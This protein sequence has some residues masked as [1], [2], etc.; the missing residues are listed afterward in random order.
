[1]NGINMA[2]GICDL[3]VPDSVI[4]GAKQAMDQGYNI[5]MPCEGFPDLR[6]AVANR[7]NTQYG[8]AVDPESQVFIS[9]GATGAFYSVCMAM[10]NPGD[11]V[12]LFEPYYGYHTATLKAMDLTPVYTRMSPPDWAIDWDHL[13]S[14]ITLRT[15]AM[16]VNTPG[17]P[18]GKVFTPNRTGAVGR[19]G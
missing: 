4:N 12:I 13:A 8:M 1:M 19:P 14:L 9:A 10:F 7:M 17:N 3:D 11:E 15:R 6:K 2:Q 18:S 16:V 5:Y